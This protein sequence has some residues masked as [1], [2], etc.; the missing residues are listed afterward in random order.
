V[1]TDALLVMDVQNGVVSRVGDQVGELLA[2]IRSAVTTARE[3]GVPVIF[4]RVAFR[5]GT[6]EVSPRNTTFSALAG[7]GDLNEGDPGTEIH[8][9]VA[10][11]AR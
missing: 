11:P 5:N 4:V 7:A 9:A 2:A 1:G 8:P 10:P 3:A 6:P